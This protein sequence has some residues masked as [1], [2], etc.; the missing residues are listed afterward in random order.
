MLTLRQ[1]KIAF[2][3]VKNQ[4]LSHNI[5]YMFCLPYFTKKLEK[6]NLSGSLVGLVNGMKTSFIYK[7]NIKV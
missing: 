3:K 6:Q 1:N 5:T 2:L 7:V 4:F